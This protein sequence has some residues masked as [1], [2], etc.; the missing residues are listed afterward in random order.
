MIVDGAARRPLTNNTRPVPWDDQWHTVRLVCD[1]ASG[2]IAV[3]FDDLETPL[4]EAIDKTFTSGR[5]GIG[6]FDDMNDFTAVKVVGRKNE[7]GK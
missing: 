5:V 7:A 6:S 2:R 3:C 4:M 1:V